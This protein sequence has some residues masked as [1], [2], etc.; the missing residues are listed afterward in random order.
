MGPEQ[1][2]LGPPVGIGEPLLPLPVGR[3]GHYG[4]AQTEM[5]AGEAETGP[6]NSSEG[7]SSAAVD[8]CQE[9]VCQRDDFGQMGFQ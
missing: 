5:A 2:R 3:F 6:W 9:F 4:A 7:L 1:R 8:L